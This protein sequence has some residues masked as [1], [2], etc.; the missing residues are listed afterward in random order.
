VFAVATVI[1]PLIGGLIVD[2]LSWRSCFGVSVPVAVAAFVVLQRTLH[3]P[4]RRR[5]VS[6]DYLGAFLVAGGISVLLGWVS[7]AGSS[8]RG[9]RPPPRG[10]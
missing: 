4:T 8:F 3:L 9:R 1:G 10:W 7:L 2:T 6:I 5:E